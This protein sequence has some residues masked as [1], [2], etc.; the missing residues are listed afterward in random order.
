MTQHVITLTY[1]CP[2]HTGTTSPVAQQQILTGASWQQQQQQQQQPQQQ[3]KQQQQQA[4]ACSPFG[5]GF[6]AALLAAGQGQAP[7]AQQQQQQQQRVLSGR[8]S[9]HSSCGNLQVCV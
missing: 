5:K 8:G 7:Q 1:M 6:Q 9:S 3:K 2:C 4:P